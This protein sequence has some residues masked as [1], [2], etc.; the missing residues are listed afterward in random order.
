MSNSCAK[1]FRPLVIEIRER[2]EQVG[3]VK[4]A[5][6]FFC[7]EGLLKEGDAR[8]VKFSHDFLEVLLA[9]FNCD[10]IQESF[11]HGVVFRGEIAPALIRSAYYC[12]GDTSS[13]FLLSSCWLRV[14]KYIR[15]RASGAR[16]RSARCGARTLKS[17][18]EV[19]K[20]KD[21]EDGR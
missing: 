18:L 15:N 19:I 10:R 4:T 13:F 17:V 5:V 9:G 2:S 11:F 6:H 8:L 16:F 1:H 20:A 14:L 21:K 7:C 12:V 3:G